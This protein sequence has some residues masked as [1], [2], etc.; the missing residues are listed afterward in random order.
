MIKEIVHDPILLGVGSEPATKEDLQVAQDLLDTLAFH[1][2]SCVGMAANMIGI[3]KRIIVF[4][5]EGA[6]MVMF[7][8]EIM[9]MS[10]PYDTQESCLS[11]LGKYILM[12]VIHLCKITDKHSNSQWPLWIPKTD[13]VEKN[14][15]DLL[16]KK[17][18]NFS[19]TIEFLATH[20]SN[21]SEYQLLHKGS[22]F[23]TDSDI[24]NE[25]VQLIITDPPYLGQVA[26]SEY[27]QLYKPFLDL[28]FNTEDEI[29][30]SSAPSRN[31]KEDEYFS[32]L[33]KVFKICSNKLKPNGYFCMYFHDSSLEVWN[34]LIT[35]LS[36]YKLKY[37][38]QAHIAKSNTL[39][40]IIS[41]KKSLNGDCILFFIKSDT[42]AYTQSGT[43]DIETIETNIIKQA[44]FLVKQNIALS[45][46]ELYDKGLMEIL[47]Q[48][49]W[50]NTLSKKYKSLVDIFE[51]H[52]K[53]DSDLSKWTL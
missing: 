4:D 18:K 53:W 25:S 44:K 46:P 15:I 23:I 14:V 24:P 47:I 49:G 21:K 16:E 34:K 30:V 33:D 43:E 7:N 10:G 42:T 17:V 31:K 52:L 3:Q 27:M 8:P 39:K 29:V 6:Y 36:S 13:C 28:N 26:Y 12:S 9:K 20:Y 48:N 19:K 51:K 41:P 35:S 11:L 32:L 45:T 37:L 22:Q 38:G 40:N 1:K 2:E 50:L 5:N